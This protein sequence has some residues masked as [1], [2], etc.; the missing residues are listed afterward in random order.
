MS[1]GRNQ[2]VLDFS[3]EE[4][5]QA[6]YEQ[7]EKVLSEAPVSYVKWDMNRSMSEVYSHGKTAEEQGGVFHKQRDFQKFCL[8]LVQAEAPDLIRVYYIT[9]RSVGHLTIQMQSKE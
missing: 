5:V 1:H 8:N 2:F 6:I 3:R 4:V 7:M 9:H